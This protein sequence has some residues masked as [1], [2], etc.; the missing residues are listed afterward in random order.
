MPIARMLAALLALSAPA[1]TA[2][3]TQAKPSLRWVEV[4]D[5]RLEGR[6]FPS[7]F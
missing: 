5:W 2:L 4:A 3:P 6:A 7:A 1:C